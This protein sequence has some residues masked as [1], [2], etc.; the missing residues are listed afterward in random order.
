MTNAKSNEKSARFEGRITHVKFDAINF[1]TMEKKSF[2][3]DTEYLRSNTMAEKAARKFFEL[4]DTWIIRVTDIVNEKPKA[5]KYNDSKIF[6]ACA[7]WFEDEEQA[8]EG[9]NDGWSVRA[10]PFFEYECAFWAYNENDDT[11]ITDYCHDESPLKMT[12]GDMRAF[13]A[14]SAH[15]LT[16]YK[17][18][19][20]HNCKREEIVRYCVIEDTALANCIES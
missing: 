18:L 20:V 11:Y 7:A 9:L 4:D 14:M 13:L 1:D 5:V 16:G 17:I 2:E 12:K 3:F 10:I 8:R 15:E 19:G 6:D